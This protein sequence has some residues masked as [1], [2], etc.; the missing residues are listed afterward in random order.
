MDLKNLDF[1]I[2]G[3]LK[4]SRTETLEKYLIGK[5]RSLGVIGFMSPFAL[6]N[7]ARCTLYEGSIKSK[8][9]PLPAFTI[10]SVKWW[11]YPMMSISFIVYIFAVL[12]SLLKLGCKFE[13]FIGIATFSITIGFILKK[14]RLVNKV[15]Y[16]CID[17][18]PPPQSIGFN[19]L[20]NIIYKKIDIAAVKRADIV[21]EISPFIQNARQQYSKVPDDSY[22]KII[23]PMGWT[24]EVNRNI[25]IKE[26][27]KWTL[28]FVG[29][30]SENQGLQ[31]VIDS[32]PKLVKKYPEI[33]VRVIGHGPYASQLKELAKNNGVNDRFIFHGFVSDD[34][35]AYNIL[36]RCM[37][38]LATY[39]GNATDNSLYADPG[40]TKLYALLGLPIII[41]SAPFV[42]QLIK[43]TGAGEVIN[44]SVDD[45]VSAVEKIMGNE[46]NYQRYLSGVERFKPYC[47]AED[48]FNKAFSETFLLWEEINKNR[49]DL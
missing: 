44:Y 35:E 39:T 18:Y 10:K 17:Y 24:Y 49:N 23:V 21:W 7:E 2:V 46:E 22:N 28:G 20:V 5:T 42:A 32:I 41:S 9:F 48:L 36:S 47:R 19:R 16:Y 29:T 14:M 31:L 1:L 15:I 26:K 27:E 43:N 13:I 3:Q 40:K 33:K 4:T 11:N 45:F 34:N 6:Y 30:I 12:K 37:I 25:P 38:G 8:E